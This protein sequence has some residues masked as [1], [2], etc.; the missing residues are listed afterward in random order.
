MGLCC[1]RSSD[2]LICRCKVLPAALALR[3]N[4]HELLTNAARLALGTDIAKRHRSFAHNASSTVAVDCAVS[5]WTA[6]GLDLE[7]N[8]LGG[9]VHERLDPRLLALLL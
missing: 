3:D 9:A 4:G 7:A 1:L 2:M 6:F 8:L 5:Q